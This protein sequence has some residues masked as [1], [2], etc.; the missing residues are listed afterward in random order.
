MALWGWIVGGILGVSVI[1]SNRK[2]RAQRKENE[3]RRN[4][5]FHF[6]SKISESEFETIVYQITDD[7][8]RVKDVSVDGPL[9]SGTVV[10]QSHLS[11]WDFTLD[12]NDYGRITGRYWLTSDN[13]DSSIPDKVGELICEAVQSYTPRTH[14]AVPANDDTSDARKV[15]FAEAEDSYAAF[16]PRT[17]SFCSHCGAAVSSPDAQFCS[18]CGGKLAVQNRNGIRFIQAVCPGCNS[19][20]EVNMD[21]LNAFCPRCGKKLLIDFDHVDRVYVEKEKT[22]REQEVTKREQEVTKRKKMEYDKEERE[23]KK[24]NKALL[25]LVLLMVLSFVSRT[26]SNRN[27]VNKHI[28]NNDIQISISAENLGNMTY[29][30]AETVLRNEG[31]ENIT[32]VPVEGLFNNMFSDPDSVIDVYINGDKDFAQSEWFPEDASVR[33]E[34]H[35]K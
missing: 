3:R 7:F 22:K 24:S 34:Y 30:E 23:D 10:S 26:V 6:D 32:L 13:D 17:H 8:R 33:I 1:K 14:R 2:F 19:Q 28:A 29:S 18:S 11:Q 16:T 15:N 9:V 20:L 35:S 12:F 21:A 4:T 25:A 27:D 31:F 5:P